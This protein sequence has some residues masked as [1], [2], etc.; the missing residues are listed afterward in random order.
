MASIA[1]CKL[2]NGNKRMGNTNARA[3]RLLFNL[4]YTHF[5]RY[6]RNVGYISKM[7]SSVTLSDA[8]VLYSGV[9]YVVEMEVICIA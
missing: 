1:D 8:T 6:G 7:H 9:A 5:L 3:L 2:C 4:R